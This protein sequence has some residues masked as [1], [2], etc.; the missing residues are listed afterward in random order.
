MSASWTI[1]PIKRNKVRKSFLNEQ[2]PKGYCND[3]LIKK[4]L[5][6]SQRANIRFSNY[7]NAISAKICAVNIRRNIVNG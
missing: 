5:C 3:N 2:H 6:N 4:A 7:D 1:M